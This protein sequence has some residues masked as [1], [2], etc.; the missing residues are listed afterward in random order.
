MICELPNEIM[1]YL[2]KLFGHYK[3][4]SL[5]RIMNGYIINMMQVLHIMP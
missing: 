2:F 4:I 5:I 1:F 3:N